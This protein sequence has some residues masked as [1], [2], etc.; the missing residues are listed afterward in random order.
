M[1]NKHS[2]KVQY[3]HEKFYDS[4][5]INYINRFMQYNENLQVSLRLLVCKTKKIEK[6]QT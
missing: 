6:K 1:T 2:Q 3:K 4:N 5:I